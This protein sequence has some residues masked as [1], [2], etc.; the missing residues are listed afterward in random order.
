LVLKVGERTRVVL[1]PECP[2][3]VGRS[4]TCG[5]VLHGDEVS[6]SHGRIEFANDKYFYVDES[7]N[8]TY[9]LTQ[10]GTEVNVLKE[11]ILLVG[12]G[13]ISP[14]VPVLKQTGE[15]LRFRCTPVHLSFGDDAATKPRG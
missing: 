10:D 2:I 4:K 7:R 13:V 12:D 9:V 1:P 5:V 15:V 3:T 6:R 8:G 11:R 14:G